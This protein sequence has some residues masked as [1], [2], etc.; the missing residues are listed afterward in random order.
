MNQRTPHN[1]TLCLAGITMCTIDL[2]IP[3][4]NEARGASRGSALVALVSQPKRTE[5]KKKKKNKK[6]VPTKD[7]QKI[8]IQKAECCTHPNER[9]HIFRKRLNHPIKDCIGGCISET[10]QE[11]L[12][13]LIQASKLGSRDEYPSEECLVEGPPRPRK[14]KRKTK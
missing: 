2:V 13:I 10:R 5:E 11:I 4:K 8:T 14:K 12:P 6:S 7:C 9:K 3:V 1:G